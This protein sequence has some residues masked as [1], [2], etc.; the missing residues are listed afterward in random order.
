MERRLGR[1]E[2][3][4]YSVVVLA[5]YGCGMGLIALGASAIAMITKSVSTLPY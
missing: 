2:W 1:S 3:R 4:R 5:G